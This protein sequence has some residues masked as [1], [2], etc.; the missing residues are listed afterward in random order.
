M[1]MWILPH[2]SACAEVSTSCISVLRL[3]L[4]GAASSQEGSAAHGQEEQGMPLLWQQTVRHMAYAV[5][6][7]KHSAGSWAA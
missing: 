4:T 3:V 1:S 2:V 7:M 5:W 6:H